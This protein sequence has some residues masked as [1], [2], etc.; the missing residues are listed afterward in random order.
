MSSRYLTYIGLIIFFVG[1][2]TKNATINMHV[3]PAFTHDR[4]RKVAIFPF[5]SA[6]LAASEAKEIDRKISVDIKAKNPRVTI[7]SPVDAIALLNDQN[8]AVYWSE[9]IEHYLV[10]RVP[11]ANVLHRIGNALGVDA[12]IQGEAVEVYQRDGV[13]GAY[14]GETRVTVR[15]SLIGVEEGKILWESSSDGFRENAITIG[16]APAII[17]CVNLAV[18]KILATIPN[19]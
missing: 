8:L 19:F 9:F 11:D 4:I 1:C 7:V 10:S 17:K 6:S 3:D 12:I 13:Y 2:A 14:V 16:K 5:R 18:D 15:L